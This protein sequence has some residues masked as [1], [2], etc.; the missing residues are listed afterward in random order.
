MNQDRMGFFYGNCASKS[1]E[2]F[3]WRSPGFDLA[4]SRFGRGWGGGGN[5]VH[6]KHIPKQCRPDTQKQC[7]P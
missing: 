3:F 4:V 2:L 6:G 7:S 1:P 5:Y